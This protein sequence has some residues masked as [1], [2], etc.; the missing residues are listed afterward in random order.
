[1]ADILT[2]SYITSLVNSYIQTE[3]TKT[4]YPL[5]DRKTKYSS[6]SSAYGTLSSKLDSFKTFLS[7][8]KLTGT[9]S[10]FSSKLANST[11]TNFISASADSTAS[12]GIYNFRVNQLAKS[13]TLISS[14]FTSTD[15]NTLTGT[16]S[17]VIKTGD[18]EGGEFLS[19]ID[20]NFSAEETNKTAMQKIRDAINADKAVVNSDTKQASTSYL[21]ERQHLR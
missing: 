3:T 19:N 8:F 5:Q 2:T 14:D 1:M 9:S 17:F 18:G 12:A 16:H 20:V 13:D 15:T 4:I 11:D 10:V 6:L 21:E 7:D